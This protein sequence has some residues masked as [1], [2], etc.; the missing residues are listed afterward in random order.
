MFFSSFSLVC[1]L[2]ISDLQITNLILYIFIYV[3]SAYVATFKLY[4]FV[5]FLRLWKLMF[6][7]E[8]FF[9]I[10][11][12]L[13]FIFIQKIVLENGSRKTFITQKW[14]ALFMNFFFFSF[15]FL[16]VFILWESSF[17]M[18]EPTKYISESKSLLSSF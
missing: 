18:L 7:D 10:F 1:K 2:F 9:K 6:F 17:K 4:F 15:F 11:L 3:E 16:S 5:L 8:K 14:L 13:C 12:Y